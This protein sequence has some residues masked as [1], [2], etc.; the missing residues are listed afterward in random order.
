[1]GDG[2]VK[3]T[4]FLTMVFDVKQLVEEEN[5]WIAFKQFDTDNDNYITIQDFKGALEQTGCFL[6]E[7]EF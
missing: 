6:T 5:L 1:M 2:K 3:Y 4:E 7:E